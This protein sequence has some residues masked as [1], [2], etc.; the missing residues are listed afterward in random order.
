MPIRLGV[1]TASHSVANFTNPW[2]LFK[3]VALFTTRAI[4]RL[5]Q[6]CQVGLEARNALFDPLVGAKELGNILHFLLFALLFSG[7]FQRIP[8]FSCARVDAT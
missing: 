3:V 8:E 5:H 1:I 4:Y 7:A 6:G 2:V